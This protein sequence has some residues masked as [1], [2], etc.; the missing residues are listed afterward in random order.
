MVG[1]SGFK[2]EFTAV[3][4]QTDTFPIILVAQSVLR[5]WKYRYIK[6][7]IDIVIALIGIVMLSPLFLVVAILVAITSGFP[8]FYPW[9]VVGQNGIP[10][11][12]YKFRTMIRGA[13]KMRPTLSQFNEAS[14]P[15]FKMQNDPRITWLG[16]ILR[17]YSIDEFP[18]LWNVLKGDISLIGPRP[19]LVSEW[20]D[21]SPYQKLKMKARP[22]AVSL[23][24]V[25][26]QPRN[27]DDWV[28]LDLEYI[29]T[30]SLTLDFKIFWGA[31][32]YILSGKNC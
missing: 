7:M 15:V 24:H 16:K 9:D 26:G 17:K 27:L 12:G 21:F 4:T 14:D 10:F 11:R 20:K 32:W 2:G 23:W 3:N 29:H 18:Q 1:L 5:R 6:R 28:A 30:W 25:R 31:V 19:P 13:E 22:G 8:I